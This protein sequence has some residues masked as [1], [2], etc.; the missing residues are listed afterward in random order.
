MFLFLLF[1]CLI[2]M[3]EFSKFNFLFIR[4]FKQSLGRYVSGLRNIRN[5]L[6]AFSAPMLHPFEKPLLDLFSTHKTLGNFFLKE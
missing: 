1:N 5:L 3:I 4:F 2:P 6:D